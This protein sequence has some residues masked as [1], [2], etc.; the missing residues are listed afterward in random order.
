[1]GTGN[2]RGALLEKILYERICKVTQKS[3]QRKTALQA[4]KKYNH[5]KKQIFFRTYKYLKRAFLKLSVSTSASVSLEASI[6]IPVFLF[7]FLEIL[8]LLSY[9][10]V[11]SGVLCAIKFAGDPVSIY[12]YVYDRVM[13]ATE[14]ASIGESLVTALVFSETYLDAQVKKACDSALYQNAVSGGTDGITLLGS[15]I[16]RTGKEVSI[17]AHYTVEPLISFAGTSLKGCNYYYARFWTGYEPEQYEVAKDMVY[18]AEYG[19]VYHLSPDCTHLQLTIKSIQKSDLW[20]ARND[21][22]K[23]YSQCPMCD[24]KEAAGNCYYITRTGDR[25]HTV[26]SCSGLKRT[27]RCVSLEEVNGWD[28]CNR[29]KQKE[30]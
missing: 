17:L 2:L 15:H 4:H 28:M 6:A 3:I 9:L 7:A 20:E 27:V 22:G 8:S 5:V 30:Q 21:Y 26:V 14:E 10:S 19:T 23:K 18:I 24:E 25:Y 11:Y 16:D 1:M 12:G 29:C 13:D